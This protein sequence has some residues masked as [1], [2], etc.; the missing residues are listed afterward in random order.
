LQ[1]PILPCLSSIFIQKI[2]CESKRWSELSSSYPLKFFVSRVYL[3][4][5][6][7]Q[8]AEQFG[9]EVRL[10]LLWLVYANTNFD[11]V[12]SGCVA[13]GAKHLNFGMV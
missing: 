13:I 4:C 11:G 1:G 8:C 5:R 6:N 2:G 3:A 9:A 10:A 12:H 7:G